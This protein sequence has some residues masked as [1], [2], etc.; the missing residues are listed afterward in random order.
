[1]SNTPPDVKKVL[2]AE[3]GFGCPVLDCGCPFLEYHH[4]DP[5][6]AVERHNR[7]EGMLA[8]CPTHHSQAAVFTVEQC[9][10]MKKNG[11]GV[12]TTQLHWMRKKIHAVMGGL[13]SF[14]CPCVLMLNNNPV[15]WFTRNEFG[16]FQLNLRMPTLG[17]EPRVEINENSI[18]FAGEPADIECRPQGKFIKIEYPNGDLISLDFKEENTDTL[19]VDI[20]LR[21]GGTD[22][23]FDPK[24]HQSTF[25][26]NTMSGCGSSYSRVGI[27]IN[28][29][30]WQ[31]KFGSPA[32]S[33]RTMDIPKQ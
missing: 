12:N 3:V 2:R 27:A 29:S 15:V 6:Q 24:T 28:R 17:T 22:I 13:S 7:P 10:E 1:M 20:G 4:F 18:E 16:L 8:I 19:R 25:G 11:Q 21:V 14:E 5:P 32:P 33:P 9:R 26:S 31:L 23:N 30:D